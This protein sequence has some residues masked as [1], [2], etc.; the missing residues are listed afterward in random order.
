MVD[1]RKGSPMYGKWFAVE[2]TARN[3]KRLFVPKGFGH[4]Y[5]TLEPDTEFL[6]KVDAPYAPDHEGGILWNDPQ[7]AEAWP[8]IPG[9][10]PILSEKDRGLGTLAAFESPFKL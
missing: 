1:L 10:E 5:L 8:S 7:L 3:Y 9:G 4:A 6:Y 2:L